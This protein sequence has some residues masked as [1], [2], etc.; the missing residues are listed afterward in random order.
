MHHSLGILSSGVELALHL[1]H[2]MP[3]FELQL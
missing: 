1:A 2:F 3:N